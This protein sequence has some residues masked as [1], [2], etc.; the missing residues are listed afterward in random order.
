MKI[1]NVVGVVFLMLL[2]GGYALGEGHSETTSKVPKAICGNWIV[3]SSITDAAAPHYEYLGLHVT[4]SSKIMRFGDQFTIKNPVYVVSK[5]SSDKFSQYF[6]HDDLSDI[7]IKG[8]SVSVVNVIDNKRGD[9]VHTVMGPGSF[10]LI[11]NKY[12]IITNWDG[13][14]YVL[15]RVGKACLD[16][17]EK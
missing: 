6:P 8:N 14:F 3:K 15:K 16:V 11:R 7:G 5:W 1:R 2:S 12:K 13:D 9:M 10:V 17:M 4:Y